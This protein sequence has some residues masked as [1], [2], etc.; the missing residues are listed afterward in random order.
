MEGPGGHK[1]KPGLYYYQQKDCQ[2]LS[3]LCLCLMVLDTPQLVL[4]I[5]TKMSVSHFLLTLSA[6]TGTL[7]LPKA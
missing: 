6:N 1:F 2:K 5:E 3:R 7:T 4:M